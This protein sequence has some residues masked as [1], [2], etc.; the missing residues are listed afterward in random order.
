MGS[1]ELEVEGL[2][3]R[4]G[5]VRALDELTLS[6]SPGEL[7]GLI[8]PNGA[9]KT[10]AIDAITG[11][12]PAAGAVRLRGR[13]VGGLAP[14][15]R[16]A[17]GLLRTFQ[18]SELFDDLDVLGNLLSGAAR[19]PGWRAVVDLVR[20]GAT[21]T[22]AVPEPV[23]RAVDLLG[24]RHLIDRTTAELSEG[25]RKLVGLGRALACEPAVLLLDE[26]AAGLDTVES[27]ALGQRLRSIVATGTAVVLVDHDVD[28]VMSICDTVHVLVQGELVVSGSP[29]SV[30]NDARV[31]AA[32]LGS[33]A[34]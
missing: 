18:R 13:D 12:T 24:I 19:P 31:I 34:A 23:D 16:V 28:L 8:G 26:P 5:G 21:A 32:Y 3:V 15:R 11:F 25:E 22:A 1:A 29:A 27:Q 30:R 7:A 6:V 20:P 4:Y 17:L 9:G 10:T 14:H 33:A 2:T